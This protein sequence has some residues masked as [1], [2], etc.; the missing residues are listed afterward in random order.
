MEVVAA[1]EVE[2]DMRLVDLDNGFVIEVEGVG[3]A[4]FRDRN[5]MGLARDKVCIT[6]HDVNGEENYLL[7]QPDVPI[8]VSRG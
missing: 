3:E 2:E 4:D 1:S 5:N 6:F 8:R 7:L